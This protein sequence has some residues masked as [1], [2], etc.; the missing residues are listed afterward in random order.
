MGPA[1]GSAWDE[2]EVTSPALTPTIP[3][4]SHPPGEAEI[5]PCVCEHQA[6]A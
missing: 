6:G 4:T 3:V 2:V 1:S 5:L